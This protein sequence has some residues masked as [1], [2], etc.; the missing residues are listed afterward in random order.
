ME[1]YI[2]RALF[3]ALVIDIFVTTNLLNQGK[4]LFAAFASVFLYFVNALVW[5]FILEATN[6]A[7]LG[8]GALGLALLMTVGMAFS[9]FRLLFGVVLFI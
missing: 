1:F 6:P 3:P 9:I 4:N 7:F 2:V 5:R 8:Q